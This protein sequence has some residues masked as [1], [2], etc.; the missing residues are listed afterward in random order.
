MNGT[1][2]TPRSSLHAFFALKWRWLVCWC[3]RFTERTK[4]NQP[5]WKLITLLVNY[6]EAE[7]INIL[8][9]KI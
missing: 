5:D 3:F 8:I 7:Q 9:E 4:A 2:V 1:I 6:H